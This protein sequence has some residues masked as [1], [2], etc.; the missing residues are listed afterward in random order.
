MVE[1]IAFCLAV[2]EALALEF[3]N[4]V[5]FVS[6]DCEATPANQRL[7]QTR[8]ITYALCPNPFCR[9]IGMFSVHLGFR[10]FFGSVCNHH[11]LEHFS[12]AWDIISA[13]LVLFG[14]QF[15]LGG[16]RDSPRP[17]QI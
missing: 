17:G 8:Q 11:L 10:N 3:R 1:K 9:D 14:N 2:L 15:R 7:A 6:V 13:L 12:S 4:R 16:N 5:S